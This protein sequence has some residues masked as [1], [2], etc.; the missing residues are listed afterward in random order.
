MKPIFRSLAALLVLAGTALAQPMAAREAAPAPVPASSAVAA[1]TPAAEPRGPA[2][3]KVADEDTT[4]YLFGTIHILPPETRWFHGEIER[5]Y[6]ESDML[7]TE[8]LIDGDP[9]KTGQIITSLAMLP[10]G[11]SLRD[12]LSE[13]QR[14]RY[15]AGL[16]SIGLPAEAFDRFKPWYGAMMTSMLPLMKE[17]FSSQSGVEKTLAATA[18]D[19]PQGELETIEGQLSMFDGMSQDVQI[20]YL[21]ETIDSL[22][23]LRPTIQQIIAEWLDG[24]AD[25]LAALMNADL[26]NPA[27]LD[28]LLYRRNSA[29][30]EWIDRRL[31]QPGTV[32]LA[33]GAGHL[34]GTKSVQDMLALRGIA[35]AR[36][37]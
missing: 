26:Q 2:L 11:Q 5:A 34:A 20:A 33:V 1:Y 10:P 9:A 6:Q 7:V 31:D 13:E 37:H 21:M 16:A 14:V 25:G 35:V 8:V 28:T 22:D 23:R 18:S 4:I 32:F 3:W 29:W 27:L 36:V 17:G 12:M 30:A 15:E 19:K 24:D